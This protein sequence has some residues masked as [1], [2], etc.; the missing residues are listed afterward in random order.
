MAA[1]EK[2]RMDFPLLFPVARGSVST[3]P[4]AAA[5]STAAA[6]GSARASAARLA[7]ADAELLD[8]P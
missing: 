2:R 7:A 6:T 3:A 1:D 4:A 5:T 8:Q